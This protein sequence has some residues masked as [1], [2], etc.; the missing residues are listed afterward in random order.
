MSNNLGYWITKFYLVF[1]W[2]L[3]YKY[4]MLKK[5]TLSGYINA[6]VIKL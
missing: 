6:I 2:T 3:T 1:Q 5:P 4:N